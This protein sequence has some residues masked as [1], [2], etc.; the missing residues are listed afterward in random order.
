MRLSPLPAEEWDDNTRAAFRGLLPRDR[1]NPEGAGT[2]MSTLARHPDLAAAYMPLGVHLNFRST[3]S[4]RV[5]ELIILRVAHRRRSDYIWSH[6]QR[7]AT[8]VGLSDTEIEAIRGGCLPDLFD[9]A[10]LD[11]VDELDDSAGL[12][13][14]TWAALSNYLD[15]QQRMDLVFTAGGYTLLAVAYNTFGIEPEVEAPR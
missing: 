14:H 12:T 8:A 4:D 15:E 10:V 11:A 1:R 6:H 3:L 9:Q 2:A 5:R 7:S 13:D